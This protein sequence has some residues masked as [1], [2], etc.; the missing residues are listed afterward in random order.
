MSEGALKLR[1]QA[2]GGSNSRLARRV[3]R[4]L[5]SFLRI[6]AASGV[7]LLAATAVAL[8]WVNGPFGESYHDFWRAEIT[9]QVGGLL[10]LS[11]SLEAWVNDGLMV[12]FFF[13]VGMEIK[14]E[15]VV[16]DLRQPRVAALPAIAA[17]GGMAVPA[18]IFLSLN[19][20]T[21]AAR[22]WGVPMA[23]DIA[24]AVGVLTLLGRRAP[25]R[26]KLFLLTLAIADDL[27]AILV[28]A[29]FYTADLSF[30]WLAVAVGL[31]VLIGAM[32]RYRVWYTPLYVAM[33]GLV[34]LATL[35]S[36]VHATIAGVVLGL[37]TPARPLLGP[38]AMASVRDLVMG[39]ATGRPSVGLVRDAAWFARESVSVTSRMSTL[40]SPWTSFVIVPLFALSN[41]GV[42]LSSDTLRG[43]L[44]SSLTWGV[45]LGLVIGKPLGITLFAWAAARTPFAELP[46]GITMRHVVGGGAVAGIG[47][48]VALFV[49]RLAFDD[50]AL[51]DEAVIGILV[52][53]LLAAVLGAV[54]LS[55][56]RPPEGPDE[57]ADDEAVLAGHR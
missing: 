24:F 47:F 55:T 27:G 26:L 46:P 5:V 7:L 53:S 38:R 12:I 30:E 40:L 16:G 35:E 8:I 11:E 37:M 4:P 44:G 56:G 50:P 41:A 14:S 42:E 17:L 13:V 18:L 29:V 20:G 6:E 21:D 25:S 32:Q 10:T 22:G 31:L 15:L 3:A 43:S 34:W 28:I 45:I 36:G 48:T 1:E 51:V 2:W 33:G 54:L 49:T 9:I 19:A 39:D 23:T 52:A 57:A